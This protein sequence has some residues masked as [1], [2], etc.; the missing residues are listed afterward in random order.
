MHTHGRNRVAGAA[1]V[2]GTLLAAA[3]AS[4]CGIAGVAS[5]PASAPSTATL[6]PAPMSESPS[7][8]PPSSAAAGGGSQSGFIAAD[9][10]DIILGASDAPLDASYVGPEQLHPLLLPVWYLSAEEQQPFRSLAGYLDAATADFRRG[11]YLFVSV[12]LIF[13]DAD[14]ASAALAAYAAESRRGW[15]LTNPEATDPG[16]GDESL[17]FSGPAEVQGG[18]PGFYYFW[19]IDNLLLE[20]VGVGDVSGSDLTA[21]ETAVAA[22]ALEM[23]RRAKSLSED[24]E[25]VFRAFN[26]AIAVG[27]EE[28]AAE[29]LAEGGLIFH[30]EVSAQ[31]VDEIVGGFSCVAELVA[32]EGSDETAEIRLR[33][34][35]TRPGAT[36]ECELIGMEETAVVTVRGGKIVAI[37]ES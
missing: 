17:L 9:L 3:L 5:A 12:A 8:V 37:D 22:M 13:E 28:R 33:F 32:V 29:L 14:A 19:R 31:S 6:P 1:R 24:A 23:E 25:H 34:V 18:E 36:S 35:E 15:G 2:A 21:M 7:V 4:G 27:N 26:A 11:T 30:Q 16:L 10:D 20:A